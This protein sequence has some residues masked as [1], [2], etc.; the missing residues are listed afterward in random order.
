[1]KRRDFYRALI[2]LPLTA[3]IPGFGLATA[4]AEGSSENEIPGGVNGKP[5]GQHVTGPV[6]QENGNQRD[7]L[8]H[9]QDH[10]EEIGRPSGKQPSRAAGPRG[11]RQRLSSAV[12]WL[13]DQG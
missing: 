6:M 3:A 1:M 4:L 9:A 2:G 8:G 7:L 11:A 10:L 13:F 12:R 5:G